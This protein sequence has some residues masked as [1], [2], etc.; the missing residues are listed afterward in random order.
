M[1]PTSA[2]VE[3]LLHELDPTR[4]QFEALA[5]LQVTSPLRQVMDFYDQ[6]R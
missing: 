6:Q 3:H 4:Q 2:V 5:I 1:K